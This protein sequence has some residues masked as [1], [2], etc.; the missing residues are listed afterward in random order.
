MERRDFLKKGSV[1][2]VAATVLPSVGLSAMG[3]EKD[4]ERKKDKWHQLANGK[5][6]LFFWPIRV[7]K[8]AIQ[9]N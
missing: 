7:I 9:C 2:V 4:D 1:A 6:G 5:K 8:L 3:F